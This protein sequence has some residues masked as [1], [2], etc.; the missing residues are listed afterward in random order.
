MRKFNLSALWYVLIS[1]QLLIVF[2]LL[3]STPSY[4]FEVEFLLPRFIIL[5]GLVFRQIFLSAKRPLYLNV[6]D[7]ILVYVLLGFFYGETAYLNTLF[8]NKI[9][10]WLMDADQWLFGFQ[11][12]LVFSSHIHSAFMSELMFM[13]YFSYYLM[14]VI[15]LAV[16][17]FKRKNHFEKTAF[18]IFT[19]FLLYYIIFIVLPAEGPQFFWEGQKAIVEAKGLFGWLVK[20][21]QEAGEA[22]TAAF[23]SSH[24]GVALIILVT[25]HELKLKL[26]WIYL[27]FVMMLVVATVYIKAHYAV[28]ALAGIISV[29]LIL[30]ASKKLYSLFSSPN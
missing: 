14:P 3:I 24:V 30:F 8:F 28:D 26:F 27:P 17:A 5:V 12:A 21:I 23:P 25:L 13:G 16:I 6:F 4:L 10:P 29:P 11:P 15:A 18:V 19:S 22:P 1:Y 2:V 7:A 20:Q 9:D